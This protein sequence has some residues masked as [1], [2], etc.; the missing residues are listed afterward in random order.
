M[1]RR[2]LPVL[3]VL[4]QSV[5]AAGQVHAHCDGARLPHVHADALLDLAAPHRGDE[6]DDDG[7]EDADHDA[8]ALYLPA[9]TVAVPAPAP[10]SAGLDLPPTPAATAW[11]GPAEPLAS[12]LGL[13]PATAGPP[14]CPLFLTLCSLRN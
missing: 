4:L 7:H 3:L 14:G 10:E 12:P 8:D 2:L 6:H 1:T 5:L 13:P 9:V 11:I